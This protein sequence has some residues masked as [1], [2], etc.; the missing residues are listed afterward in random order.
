[1][2]APRKLYKVLVGKPK[3]KRPLRSLR[4]KWDDGI[5]MNLGEIGWG[6]CGVDST[7]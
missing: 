6:R 3:G 7:G 1:M 4:H 2:A 5:R